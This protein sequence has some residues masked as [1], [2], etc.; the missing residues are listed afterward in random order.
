MPLRYVKAPEQSTKGHLDLP[1][2]PGVLMNVS[3][4]TKLF[5]IKECLSDC[6]SKNA[7]ARPQNIS[8]IY[9]FKF[10][11]GP[12]LDLVLFIFSIFHQIRHSLGNFLPNLDI[13]LVHFLRLV[14]L[15]SI[16]MTFEIES[17][18]FL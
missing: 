4:K 1:G 14:Q 5:S 8:V 13:L 2:F 6:N 18:S 9:I 10:I 7:S 3:C 16:L 11:F 15:D 17:F 12:I